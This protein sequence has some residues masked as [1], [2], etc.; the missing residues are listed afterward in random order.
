MRADS[1]SSAI[2]GSVGR[3]RGSEPTDD[4][5][6]ALELLLTHVE[7]LGHALDPVLEDALDARLEGHGRGRAAHAGADQLDGHDAGR[8]VH[9]AQLDVAAVGLDR[10]PDRLD[11]LLDLLSHGPILA[12]GLLTPETNTR[13]ATTCS[14]V[15]AVYAHGFGGT[16]GLPLPRWLLAYFIGFA[17]VLAFIVLRFVR[18]PSARPSRFCR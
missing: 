7:D 3:G 9:V 6:G 4:E 18:P 12:S 2:G 16:N 10:R 14:H 1:N 17:I 13:T 11:R 15:I 5:W 8:L